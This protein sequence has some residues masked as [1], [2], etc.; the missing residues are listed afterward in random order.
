MGSPLPWQGP[1]QSSSGPGPCASC[2]PSAP[3]AAAAAAAPAGASADPNLDVLNRSLTSYIDEAVA[4]GQRRP[5]RGWGPATLNNLEDFFGTHP[6]DTCGTQTAAIEERLKKELGPSGWKFH[7]VLKGPLTAYDSGLFAH[8][9]LQAVSPDGKTYRVDP[10]YGVVEPMPA[11]LP[12]FQ[13][14]ESDMLAAQE[15][16][17]IDAD[18]ERRE[19]E[20]RSF[21][22]GPGWGAVQNRYRPRAR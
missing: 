7:S 22:P 1:V 17:M 14:Y 21:E 11:N 13:V 6:R 19:L 10:L 2:S 5:G 18:R 4:S 8:N 9:Y 12:M 16:A 20:K 3:A 15:K